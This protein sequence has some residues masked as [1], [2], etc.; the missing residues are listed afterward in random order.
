M[1]KEN[2]FIVWGTYCKCGNECSI[3]QNS[4]HPWSDNKFTIKLNCNSCGSEVVIDRGSAERFYNDKLYSCYEGVYGKVIDLGC[5][6]GFL[7]RYLL[8]ENKVDKI[9]GLD[10]DDDCENELADIIWSE[11]KFKFIKGDIKE[12]NNIFKAN[13]AD[14]L[15]SRDVFMFIEDTEKYFED[16][17]SIVSRGIRQ[18]GWY[19]K[20]NERMKNKLEPRQIAEQYEKKGWKVELEYLNW[21]KYGY[22]IY[23]NK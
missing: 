23:A 13:S 19:V 10:V 22:A 14:F 21:Y 1:F 11:N 8:K 20:D 5:G 18:L 6:E 16:V 4:H 15:V 2:N 3:L 7:S 9:Y 12:I 17:T